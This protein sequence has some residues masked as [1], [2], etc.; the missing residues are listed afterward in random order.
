MQEQIDGFLAQLAAK[1]E[2]SENT[3]AAYRND[4]NQLAAFL[5]GYRS[6]FGDEVSNWR[7]VDSDCT[8]GVYAGNE[9]P[10]LRGHDGRPQ[11]C[12]HEKLL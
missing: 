4:L 2:A 7:Q 1:A 12:G 10:R 11:G 6:P 8:P 5:A 3:V 9:G